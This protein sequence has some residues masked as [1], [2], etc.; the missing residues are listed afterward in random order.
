M[1]LTHLLNAKTSN[2][3][4]MLFHAIHFVSSIFLYGMVQKSM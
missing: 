3:Q 1:N 2:S 4:E